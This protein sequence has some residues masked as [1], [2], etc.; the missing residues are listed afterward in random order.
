MLIGKN[1]SVVPLHCCLKNTQTAM[2]EDLKREI[3]NYLSREKNIIFSLIF[4]SQVAGK[5]NQLSDID[6][7]IY[8]KTEMELLEM[9]RIIFDLEKMIGKKI[10]LVVLND[11]FKKD[12]ALAFEIISNSEILFVKDQNELVRFKRLVYLYFMDTEPLRKQ[13]SKNMHKR[14]DEMKFGMF[15]YA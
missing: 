2:T 9:G 3:K 8:S 4:G 10:D 6:I 5:A 12:P 11:I 13:I 1:N 7:G 15:N 14:I